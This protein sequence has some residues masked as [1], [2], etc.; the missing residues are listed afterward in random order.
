MEKKILYWVLRFFLVIL[1]V[2][3]ESSNVDSQSEVDDYN[4]AREAAWIFID[5]NGWNDTAKK[6]NWQNAKVTTVIADGDYELL[7]LS[8]EG[9]EALAIVFEEIEN[10]VVAPPKILVDAETNKVVGYMP[11][12]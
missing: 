10:A 2:G 11:S 12:E 6:E 1:L 8:Y 4:K 7:D 9:E 5:E 3:C